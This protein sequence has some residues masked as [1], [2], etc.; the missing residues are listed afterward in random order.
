MV[1]K[2]LSFQKEG[3]FCD[4]ALVSRCNQI[5]Y[6][7]SSILAS[8]CANLI[9]N[10]NQRP[11]FKQV[12]NIIDLT[13]FG[14]AAV[15][16]MVTYVYTGRPSTDGADHLTE[17]G[18]LCAYLGIEMNYE[19]QDVQF[20]NAHVEADEDCNR[21]EN[22]VKGK[23]QEENGEDEVLFEINSN[24]NCDVDEDIN[25]GGIEGLSSPFPVDN[26]AVSDEIQPTNCAV[27]EMQDILF[28]STSQI[29]FN[30]T[31]K[32]PGRRASSHKFRPYFK[33]SN[34]R[35]FVC[36]ECWQC[37]CSATMLRIH[38][39]AK[40]DINCTPESRPVGCLLC[41][42]VY[43][44]FKAL[45]SHAT[46]HARRFKR[47]HNFE[48]LYCSSSRT[49]KYQECL[50]THIRTHHSN[51]TKNTC[52]KTAQNENVGY[53]V[54]FESNSKNVEDNC[55]VNEDS[56]DGDIERFSSPLPVD[57]LAVSEQIQPTNFAGTEM[58]E[59]LSQ[60][61]SQLGFNATKIPGRRTSSYEFGP[62]F[63]VTN[64]QAFVCPECW[65]CFRSAIRLRIHLRAKHDINCTPTSRPL[66]CLL[67]G[68]VFMRFKALSWHVKQ[69][70]CRSRRKRNHKCPYCSHSRTFKFQEYLDAHIQMHHSSSA[71]K[72]RIKDVRFP[73][74]ACSKTF[75]NVSKLRTHELWHMGS[76][77]YVCQTCGKSYQ[78]KHYLN[79]HQ[80][81]HGILDYQC[82][83]CGKLCYSQKSLTYHVKDHEGHKPY[84]CQDCR[85]R[86]TTMRSLRRHCKLKQHSVPT[87]VLHHVKV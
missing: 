68:Q 81:S 11:V 1:A 40:H 20:S 7:H 27:A 37:F 48:C 49:F 32:V 50:N 64:K 5:I 69:H 22:A 53:E 41:G 36:P 47:K 2:Q 33:V 77:Q 73:C 52:R 66:S 29:A 72:I 28:Q 18:K 74:F 75:N 84:H 60:A 57:K 65:Q 82:P 63:K 45:S 6:A 30:T 10:L 23:H 24:S 71:K 55:D 80:V 26:L 14:A 86:F 79:R 70:Y 59:I 4:T 15:Q 58:Q 19:N 39:H 34:K 44:H 35:P 56:N 46:L 38:L 12:L 87:A 8:V 54:P 31:T 25:D 85:H 67:C 62:R 43:R 3:L 78:N 21:I 83:V 13:E 76:L 51:F 17:L 42:Q 9:G 61:T 16:A